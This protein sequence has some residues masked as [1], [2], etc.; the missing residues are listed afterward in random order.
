MPTL[1][2]TKPADVGGGAWMALGP[3]GGDEEALVVGR[4]EGAQ[5]ACGRGQAD[6]LEIQKSHRREEGITPPKK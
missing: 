4:G 3:Q 1:T 6:G 2:Q 5:Q